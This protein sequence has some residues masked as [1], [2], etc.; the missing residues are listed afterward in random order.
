VELDIKLYYRIALL[1]Q[2]QLNNIH[3]RPN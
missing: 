1:D 3:W 2:M